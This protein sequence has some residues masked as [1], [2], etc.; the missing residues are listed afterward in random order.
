[1][2]DV[3]FTTVVNGDIEIEVATLG[4]GPLV[5]FVHGWPELWY[6]WRHQMTHLAG[7]GFR[8]AA[9]NVRGYGGSSNP[10]EVERYTM[11]EITGDVAAVVDAL[12]NGEPAIVIG[13]DWGAPIAWNTARLHPDRV[14]AVMGMS[15][16]YLPIGPTSSLEIFRQLYADKFFYQLYF[17]QPGV[18][19][20]ELGADHGRSLRMIYH[21]ASGAAA[22]SA[23]LSGDKP[24]DAKLLDG[25]VDPG[26]PLAHLTAEELDVYVAAYERSGWHGPINR[27]RAQDLDAAD[28]GHLDD[29]GVLT[30]PA[31]FVGGELDGVRHFIPGLDLFDLAPRSCGDW[32]GTTIVPGAGHWVQQ[33]QP[34]ATNAAI[35]DFLDSL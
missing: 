17:Q 13:H 19:E 4:S 15:V 30:Q 31:A 12:G 14:R 28:I 11:R 29:D 25:M 6:S 16:P 18:A 27:Y 33:E 21:G 8:A 22:G 9:M 32:R 7:R 2:I 23:G 34:D 1:M 10:T 5:V 26:L 3:E 20:A 24:A 35:D